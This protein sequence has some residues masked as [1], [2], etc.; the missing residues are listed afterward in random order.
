MPNDNENNEGEGM[1]VVDDNAEGEGAKRIKGLTLREYEGRKLLI[2][3]RAFLAIAL[4]TLGGKACRIVNNFTRD[5][6][7]SR[8][9]EFQKK[10]STELDEKGELKY[11][12]DP[13]TGN[14][15]QKD[16][17]IWRHLETFDGDQRELVYIKRTLGGLEISKDGHGRMLEDEDGEPIRLAKVVAEKL[18]EAD[19]MLYDK[20]VRHIEIRSA[21]HG[22]LE[23]KAV[24]EKLPKRLIENGKDPL[25]AFKVG[26]S[27]HEAG[28]AVNVVN[29]CGALKVLG[30][31][32]DAE[33]CL[34]RAGLIGGM[35]T[36]GP[37]FSVEHKQKDGSV[38]MEKTLFRNEQADHFQYQS[39]DVDDGE[40]LKLDIELSKIELSEKEEKVEG[41]KKEEKKSAD[42]K[43]KELTWAEAW[44]KTVEI[45]KKKVEEGI[46]KAKEGIEW[47]KKEKIESAEKWKT[48][49]RLAEFGYRNEKMARPTIAYM[50]LT[51]FERKYI[52]KLMEDESI[53]K[54]I[55]AFTDK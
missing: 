54:F 53:K 4:V 9:D 14:Y 45:A 29:W 35:Y 37:E 20:E 18:I 33:R 7:R 48:L 42:E 15:F 1:P 17:A 51:E 26:N 28:F 47:L 5:E 31:G 39:P 25:Q 11:I 27:F 8:S 34:V 19:K 6:I 44:E 22:N 16:S 10:L 21:F 3:R 32:L 2:G 52:K 12:K 30:G 24:E 38:K 23:Q 13:I 43:P 55:A 49:K 36:T 40:G 46:D 41:V 50:E